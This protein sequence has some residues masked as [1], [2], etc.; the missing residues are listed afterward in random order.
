MPLQYTDTST[1]S[2][3]GNKTVNKS[4]NTRFPTQTTT[5][6]TGTPNKTGYP[7]CTYCG[8]GHPGNF[9]LT[10]H[11]DANQNTAIPWCE[12]VEGSYTA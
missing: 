1:K 12:S 9:G 4:E 11:L 10:S 3:G 5:T 8:K 6:T 2:T 7:A